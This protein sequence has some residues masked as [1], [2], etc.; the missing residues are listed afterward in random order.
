M[1]S[2]LQNLQGFLSSHPDLVLGAFVYVV[3]GLVNGLLP[4]KINGAALTRILSGILDRATPTTRRDAGGTFKWPVFAG[5]ILRGVADAIDPKDPPAGGASTPYR[6]PSMPSPAR[7]ERPASQRVASFGMV[8][9]FAAL[10][11]LVGDASCTPSPRPNGRYQPSGTLATIDGVAR[12]LGVVAP[13]L[14]PLVLAQIPASDVDGRRAADISLTAFEGTASAWLAARRTWDARGNAGYC[15]AYIATGALTSGLQDV[16]R[17]M[18]RAGVGMNSELT[19]LVNASGLLADRVAYCDPVFDAAVPEDADVDARAL[20]RSRSVAAE[21]RAAVEHEVD[22]A[23]D[24]GRPLMPL[25]PM[26]H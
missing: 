22:A 23:R 20:L 25:P 1:N 19:D 14:K 24:R 26:R 2:L 10:A 12:I 3:L 6:E 5:S 21:L 9:A 18:G 7:D 4:T 11:L 8:P 17:T 15:D 13:F 16:I